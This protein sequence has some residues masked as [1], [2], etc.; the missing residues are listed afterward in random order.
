MA[1]KCEIDFNF[2]AT[3]IRDYTRMKFSHRGAEI[4]EK[5][6][7]IHYDPFSIFLSVTFGGIRV[8]LWQKKGR[9]KTGP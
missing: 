4:T 2:F 6:L 8:N 7:R 1:G 5:L 9:S 3:N